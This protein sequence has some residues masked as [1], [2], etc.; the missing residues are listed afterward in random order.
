MRNRDIGFLTGGNLFFRTL[1][2]RGIFTDTQDIINGG[3]MI[4]VEV[5]RFMLQFSGSI[6][7]SSFPW[8]KTG[9]EDEYSSS[10]ELYFN[11]SDNAII[12]ALPGAIS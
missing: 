9:H 2:E 3:A 8:N 1:L 11:S 12:Q 5:L 4:H 10:S 7:G 6:I